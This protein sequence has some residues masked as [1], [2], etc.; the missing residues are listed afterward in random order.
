M[1]KQK[2]T[3]Q[4]LLL[5]EKML[6]A[7]RQDF[8]EFEGPGPMSDADAL[9]YM[10]LFLKRRTSGLN[11]DDAGQVALFMSKISIVILLEIGVSHDE[12]MELLKVDRDVI[13]QMIELKNEISI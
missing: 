13:S 11:E 9:Q 8:S 10:L 12:I 2:S 4:I 5:L 7:I 1:T 3:H 6:L